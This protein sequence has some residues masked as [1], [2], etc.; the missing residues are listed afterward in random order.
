MLNLAEVS[1][2]KSA[3]RLRLPRRESIIK[4]PLTSLS[5]SS[6]RKRIKHIMNSYLRLYH[7][8]WPKRLRRTLAKRWRRSR[9][10]RKKWPNS[11]RQSTSLTSLNTLIAFVMCREAKWAQVARKHLISCKSSLQS[12]TNWSKREEKS[13]LIQSRS[14]MISQSIATALMKLS[15]NLTLATQVSYSANN[16][17]AALEKSIRSWLD[18]SCYV[19]CPRS[20]MASMLIPR[21]L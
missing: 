9:E 11:L 3:A 15:L 16:S 5:R 17:R 19:F 12:Q 21:T 10:K 8:S 14:L 1:S 6:C 13:S 7:K 4:M 18:R 2:P 20:P